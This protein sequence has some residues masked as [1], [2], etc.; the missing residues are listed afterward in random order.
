MSS[1]YVEIS[2]LKQDQTL[3]HRNIHRVSCP[4]FDHSVLVKFAEFPWQIPFF[5]AET[6]AHQW[7]DG[8]GIGPKF[9][10]HVTEA[11]RVIGFVMEFVDGARTAEPGDLAACQSILARLHALGIKHG[12]INKHNFLVKNGTVVLVDFETAQKCS[13]KEELE[14]EYR[15]L[16]QSLKDPS[17]KGGVGSPIVSQHLPV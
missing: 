2:T 14:S 17:R 10:G 11:G 4:Q 5:E 9:L 16:E 1:S 13:V 15:R 8:K 6:I 7:I 12:D 3:I